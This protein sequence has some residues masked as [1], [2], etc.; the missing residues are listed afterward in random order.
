MMLSDT[1]KE[2]EKF[3]SLYCNQDHTGKV[4]DCR[5]CPNNGIFVG[6]GCTH[7]KNPCNR[8]KTERRKGGK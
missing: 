5:S 3:F 6:E 7:L 2:I 8:I 4:P 1:L